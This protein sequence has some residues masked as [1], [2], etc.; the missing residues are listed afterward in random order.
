MNRM[1][2]I[3]AVILTALSNVFA[4]TIPLTPDFR[5][6]D[7]IFINFQQVKTNSPIPKSKIITDIPK[8]DINFYDKL[9][10]QKNITIVTSEGRKT[11]PTDKIWGY[12]DDGALYVRWG[13][14]FAKL[15]TKGALG[16]FAA[17]E[18][19][20]TYYSPYSYW[21]YDPYYYTAENSRELR[22]FILDFNTGEVYPFT[23]KALEDLFKKYDPQLY[24]EYSKLRPKKKR[25]LKFVYLR[26][27]NQ[28]NK[29][30]IYQDNE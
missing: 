8:W 24:E 16:Y 7:G 29:T 6:K 28:R 12:S 26:K 25:N 14:D 11:V 19:V 15:A 20:T 23:V 1:I 17:T 5:F 27:F 21:Y 3:I 4:D 10:N 30:Y 13:D 2:S 9:I 22:Q 18:K